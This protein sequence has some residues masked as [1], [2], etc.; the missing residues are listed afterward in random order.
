ME[1]TLLFVTIFSVMLEF[2]IFCF[3]SFLCNERFTNLFMFVSYLL[4]F[5]VSIIFIFCRLQFFFFFV[6]KFL[7]R[8]Q[9]SIG[10]GFI[11]L[12]TVCFGFESFEGF[13]SDHFQ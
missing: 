5:F 9:L 8:L 7:L 4:Q 12:F 1:R 6:F 13:K 10:R 3:C 11:E 2:S